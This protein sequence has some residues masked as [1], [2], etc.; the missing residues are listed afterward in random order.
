MPASPG[1][2]R[3]FPSVNGSPSLY[4]SGW[5]P[6]MMHPVLTRRTSVQESS[7]ASAS[8]VRDGMSMAAVAQSHERACEAL[9][10]LGALSWRAPTFS[11]PRRTTIIFLRRAR[12][13]LKQDASK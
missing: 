8:R 12:A 5:S 6:F 7:A 4:R 2:P 11:V 10:C 3:F 1:H 9:A 13:L